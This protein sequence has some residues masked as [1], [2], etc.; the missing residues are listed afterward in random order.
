MKISMTLLCKK[1]DPSTNSGL[2]GQTKFEALFDAFN[3]VQTDAPCMLLTAFAE[4]LYLNL[5]IR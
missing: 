3:V 5:L 2:H 1:N 4:F